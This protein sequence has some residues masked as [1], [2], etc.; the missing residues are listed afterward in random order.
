M[1]VAGGGQGP[2]RAVLL[3]GAHCC[4]FSGGAYSEGGAAR[5]WG[6]RALSGGCEPDVIYSS[7]LAE[8]VAVR[9]DF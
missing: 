2:A 5:V 6:K 3:P 8:T 1:C 4:D 7:V 9:C